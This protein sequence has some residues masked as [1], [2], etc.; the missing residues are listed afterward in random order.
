MDIEHPQGTSVNS[1]FLVGCGQPTSQDL[2]NDLAVGKKLLCVR[3][4]T[5]TDPPEYRPQTAVAAF[6][7]GWGHAD[8]I[9][10]DLSLLVQA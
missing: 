3:K 5:L 8:H 10:N 1:P 7:C 9:P 6:L 4:D 2:E